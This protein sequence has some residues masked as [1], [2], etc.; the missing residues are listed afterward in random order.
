MIHQKKTWIYLPIE[1]KSREL[2]PKLLLS[3]F[4]LREGF[5]VFLGKNGMNISR[6]RF[7]A[8]IYFDKCLS[9]HKSKFHERQVLE[10]G[11]VLVSHEEEGLLIESEDA[12]SK[13]R[14]SKVSINLSRLI[15]LWGSRQAGI[16]QK[17]SSVPNE[18][19]VVTGSPRIDLWRRASLGLIKDEI[20]EIQE[21]FGEF[22]FIVSNWGYWKEEE[23]LRLDPD[24]TYPGRWRTF[25]RQAFISLI[26]EVAREFP[27]R[28]LVVRPHPIESKTYWENK[29]E[30]FP[31]NVRVISDGP[32]GPWI[33][34]AGTVIHNNCTT[35]LE[36]WVG[37]VPTIAYSPDIEGVSNL[38]IYLMPILYNLQIQMK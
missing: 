1:V 6:D 16:F 11:N 5:G 20:R 4:A 23:D 7:P 31:K 26:F 13:E 33:H 17:Y 28:I 2:L 35:G 18:K 12:Y 38:D 22:I 9:A 19:L 32:I 14:C 15:F 37:G 10:F 24:K 25:M 30:F 29:S 21:T 36:S 27:S 3:Y 8:G 34:A